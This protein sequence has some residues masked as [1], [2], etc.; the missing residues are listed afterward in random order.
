MM[1]HKG[2]LFAPPPIYFHYLL[3]LSLV[4]FLPKRS[5]GVHDKFKATRAQVSKIE[6]SIMFEFLQLR[7]A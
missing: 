6:P 3:S 5:M 7:V 1:K 4:I 2:T